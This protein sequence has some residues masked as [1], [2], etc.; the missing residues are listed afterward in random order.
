MPI[1]R[2]KSLASLAILRR[3]FPQRP[4]RQLLPIAILMSCR[5]F[6]YSWVTA[7]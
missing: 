7:A 6:E 5:L 1:E 2:V 3:P 4:G